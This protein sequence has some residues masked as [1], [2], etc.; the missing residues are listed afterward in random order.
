MDFVVELYFE[1]GVKV[2]WLHVIAALHIKFNACQCWSVSNINHFAYFSCLSAS[3]VK[4]NGKGTLLSSHG[5]IKEVKV[6]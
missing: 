2:A 5:G 4:H 1:K 3:Q 6:L